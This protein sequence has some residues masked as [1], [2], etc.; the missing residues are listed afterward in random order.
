MNL[1][2]QIWHVV[3]RKIS[4]K[5]SSE[6]MHNVMRTPGSCCDVINAVG[7]GRTKGYKKSGYVMGN[8]IFIRPNAVNLALENTTKRLAKYY[9]I[10]LK[11]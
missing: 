3:V 1:D 10:L 5:V 11:M 7:D 4:D 2:Y 9:R 6:N 8:K